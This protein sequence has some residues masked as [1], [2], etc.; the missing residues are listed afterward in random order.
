MAENKNF[1]Q[2]ATEYLSKP[3]EASLRKMASY[4]QSLASSRDSSVYGYNT[5]AGFWETAELKEIGDGTANCAVV[6]CL[7]VLATSFR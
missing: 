4:N 5:T 7:N 1:L 6:A 3:S 2:R